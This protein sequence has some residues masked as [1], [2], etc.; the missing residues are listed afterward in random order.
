MINIFKKIFGLEKKKKKGRYVS[1]GGCSVCEGSILPRPDRK[2]EYEM[3]NIN[4]HNGESCKF[5]H[6][7]DPDHGVFGA[8]CETCSRWNDSLNYHKGESCR[9]ANLC[10]PGIVITG[11]ECE[12]CRR[13]DNYKEELFE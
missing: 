11:A 1:Y 9:F 12:T 8:E 10:S 3:K 13:W 6:L 5:N 2:K 4:R 7:C